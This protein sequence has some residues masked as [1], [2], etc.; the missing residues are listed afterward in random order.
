MQ[1]SDVK[2][3]KHSQTESRGFETWTWLHWLPCTGRRVIVVSVLATPTLSKAAC[4]KPVVDPRSF[5]TSWLAASRRGEINRANS[6]E[7]FD[8]TKAV[9][10]NKGQHACKATAYIARRQC[11]E[12]CQVQELPPPCLGSEAAVDLRVVYEVATGRDHNGAKPSFMFL[13][14]L[15]DASKRPGIA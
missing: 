3:K 7:S 15:D 11:P 2:I 6:N 1:Y 4:S 9:N 10:V 12:A 13:R 14:A 5:C 8:V